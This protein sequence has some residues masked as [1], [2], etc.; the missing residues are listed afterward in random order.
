LLSRIGG[1]HLRGRV[2]ASTWRLSLAGALSDP[3][4]LEVRAGAVEPSSDAR[5]TA[6]MIK[7]LRVAV[8]PSTDRD[9]LHAVEDLMLVS[10]DPPMNLMG[11]TKSAVRTVL[12]HRRRDL[13]QRI[14]DSLLTEST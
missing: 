1:N 5:L 9:A 13:T 3:L 12:S 8:V 4:V 11:M 7:H 2:T 10:L 14:S 6:W